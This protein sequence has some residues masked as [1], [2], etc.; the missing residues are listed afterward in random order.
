M[1]RSIPRLYVVTDRQQ[2]AGRPLEEVVV[3]AARGGAGMVQLREKDLTARELYDLGARLQSLLMPH[4]IP[5][6][7]ND[8][9]DVAQALDAAGVHLAGHSLS[10]AQA[11]RLLGPEKLLG[12]STHSLDEARQAMREGVDFIV[13]GPV[14]DTPSKRQYGTPQGL[15]RLAEVVAHVTC[16][17]IAIGGIDSENLPQVL[18]TGAH[19]VAMIRAVLAA[20]DPCA[21][22]RQ[23]RR[24]L[25]SS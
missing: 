3:A 15:Q 4:G 8:R 2:T 10:P 24:H 20:P 11:R 12:V 5:L 18:Q 1:V 14:Y 21:A 23:L 17:V 16:P 19:G 13:F 7:I 22:T 9:L 6:L 25:S